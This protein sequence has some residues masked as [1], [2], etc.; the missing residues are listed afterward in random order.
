MSAIE[1]FFGLGAG[2]LWLILAALLAIGEIAI[3]PG[4]FLIFIAAAA[5]VTGTITLFTDIGPVAQFVLFGIISLISVYA[6]HHFYKRQGH[7][8]A[9]PNLND[10]SAQMV[11][12]M[13]VVIQPV[14]ES[15]GRVRVGDSEW[16]ARGPNL[17]EGA[18]GRIVKVVDG[19]IQ[20]ES[21]D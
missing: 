5:T 2:W 8:G 16:P 1:Q 4:V 13:V 19:Y 21:I 10:R 20:L 18:K 15:G 11:G 17:P 3:A 12:Q 9:M 14:S 7:V 6:G